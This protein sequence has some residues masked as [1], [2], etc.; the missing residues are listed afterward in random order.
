MAVPWIREQ[1]RVDPEPFSGGTGTV[2]VTTGAGTQVGDWLIAIHQTAYRGE[3]DL[4]SPSPGTWDSI[5]RSGQGG[6]PQVQLRAWRR[7]VTTAG[8]QTVTISLSGSDTNVLAVLVVADADPDDPIAGDPASAT[9]S[10]G[11]Q[12]VGSITTPTADSLLIGAWGSYGNSI[13]YT[14]MSGEPLVDNGFAEVK[15]S[16]NNAFMVAAQA[17]PSAGATGSRSATFTGGP[18]QGWAGVL[19]A[20]ALRTVPPT[21]DAG[22]DVENH[23][24]ESQLVIVGTDV[25]DGGAPITSRNWEIVSGPDG[26]VASI[27]TSATLTWTPT[28]IGD[29]VLRYSATNSA[30]TGSD[31][32]N[33]QIVGVPVEADLDDPGEIVVEG[34]AVGARLVVGLRP[35]PGDIAVEGASP[36]LT[37]VIP[38]REQPGE[39]VVEGLAIAAARHVPLDPPVAIAVEVLPATMLSTRLSVGPVVVEGRPIQ[40]SYGS[41]GVGGRGGLIA[42]E[43]P[44]PPSTRYIVQNILTGEFLSWDLPLADVTI[45][46]EL[47]GPT[48]ISGSLRP[49]DPE[50]RDLLSSGM[51]PWSCWI[52]VETDGLIRASGIL[53]PYQVDDEVYSIEAAGPSSYL[54]GLPFLSEISAIAVDPADIVRAIWQHVQ[55]Y[56]DG[57]LGIQVYGETPVRIGEEEPEEDVEYDDETNPRPEGPYKL[58]WW[59]APDCGREVENL[60]RETPFDFVERCAWLPDRSGVAHWIELY[61]PR[62]GTR[63]TDLRFATGEN[64]IGNPIPAEETD[65]LY[66]SQVVVFG[67]GEGRDVVRGYAGRRMR[68]RLRRVAVLQDSTIASRE[69]ATAIA[70]ADI[71]RRQGL[72]DV[73]D[74]EVDARHENALFGT[75][76][77]GDDIPIDVEIPWLGRLRQ[78]ERIISITYAPDQES[79]RLQLRRAEA[80]RYG[81]Q[82]E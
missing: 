70:G 6:G 22:P 15:I 40:V 72:M 7:K 5:V 46:Y 24:V 17:V 30:G 13:N 21:V 14:G 10:S 12:T 61:Y 73:T 34:L 16:S 43:V 59:E 45:T 75:Y 81:G 36:S 25:D 18:S 49:E 23:P 27:G 55:S 33:V 56:P 80:F 11:T 63:R 48:I 28:T 66:A 53:M 79:V 20:L 2:S 38:P 31:D 65:D 32:V 78:W 76:Q 60:A 44:N 4:E 82:P 26:P 35:H 57:N 54:Y 19:F 74:I 77:V 41:R 9:G 67:K 64:V 52:H 58:S 71:E 3:D 39:L 69:R 37:H 50:I 51:E 62:A 68:S 47:S 8:A 42:V 29:Y 1:I